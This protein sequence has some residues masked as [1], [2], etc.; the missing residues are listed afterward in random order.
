M[1]SENRPKLWTK[2]RKGPCENCGAISHKIKSVLKEL[3]K[4]EQNGLKKTQHTTSMI[5]QS[6]K[7]ILY[8]KVKEIDR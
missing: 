6:R 4:L 2:F 8:T 1:I 3:E 7:L 5:P